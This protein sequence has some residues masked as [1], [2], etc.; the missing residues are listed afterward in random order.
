MSLSLTFCPN[1]IS[2][3]IQQK[4]VRVTRHMKLFVCSVG[5][6][7]GFLPY[8]YVVLICLEHNTPWYVFFMYI[9]TKPRYMF[10]MSIWFQY[11]HLS[12]QW[13]IMRFIFHRKTKSWHFHII[14]FLYHGVSLSWVLLLKQDFSNIYGTCLY[15]D[16]SIWR[17]CLPWQCYIM[18][19]LW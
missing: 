3:L 13:D 11:I 12:L 15:H 16:N 14:A 18:T 2:K 6:F 7:R 4:Q 5:Y 10:R 17:H 1:I 8:I 9:S 19:F